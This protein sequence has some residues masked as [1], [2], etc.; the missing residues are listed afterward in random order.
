MGNYSINRINASRGS[1]ELLAL[2]FFISI[3]FAAPFSGG[4]VNPAVTLGMLIAGKIN[5]GMSI[6]YWIA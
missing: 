6:L 2:F 4:H 5:F 3:C 1:G